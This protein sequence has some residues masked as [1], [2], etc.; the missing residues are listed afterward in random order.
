MKEEF[1]QLTIIGSTNSVVG[2]PH[3][4]ARGALWAFAIAEKQDLPATDT[5]GI[6]IDEIFKPSVHKDLVRDSTTIKG[7]WEPAVDYAR[8]RWQTI[9]APGGG[10]AKRISVWQR[11]LVF[12]NDKVSQGTTDVLVQTGCT[13]ATGSIP[14][15]CLVSSR[16]SEF[17]H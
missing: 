14:A 16:N 13:A 2:Q 12:E 8:Q 7:I 6:G 3:P 5:Y 10:R 17:I 4:V 9:V 11:D 1:P 15:W